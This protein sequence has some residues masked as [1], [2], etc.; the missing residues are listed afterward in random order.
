MSIDLSEFHDVFFEECFDGLDILESGLLTLDQSTD[1]EDINAIFR[2]AHSIKGGSASF[3]FMEISGFTH[4]METL[5]DEMRDGRRQVTRNSIDLLLESVDILRGMVNAARDEEDIDKPLITAVQKKLETML[6]SDET[7]ESVVADN[8]VV[9]NE[10]SDSESAET[11]PSEQ[12]INPHDDLSDDRDQ[13][14]RILYISFYPEQTILQGGNDPERIFRELESLGD[15]VVEIDTSSLPSLGEIKA[16]NCYLGWQLQL[17]GNVTKQD[18]E[19]LFSWVADESKLEISEQT[20]RQEQIDLDAEV[21][22]QTET[23]TQSIP[24]EIAQLDTKADKENSPVDQVVET[25][26]KKPSANTPAKESGSIRVAIDKIDDLINLVGE[27]VITQSMLSQT[28]ADMAVFGSACQEKLCDGLAQLERNTRELQESV[29]QIRML[30]INFTFSRFPRLVRDLSSKMG[31]QIELTM[32]G[33]NTEVDKTVLE[34]IG[35]PLVHLIRNSLDH[36]IE[37][38][39]VRTANGKPAIGN[40]ELSAYHEGGDIIIKV[41][42]DGA[43]LNRDRILA[44]AIDKGLAS[45]NEALTD[46]RIYNLIFA[47][48]F[49]TAEQVSDVSGRGV[50]MDVV[51][52]NVRDLGGNVTIN[53]NEGAGSTV[54]I[55]LPLT[56]AILDGQLARVG[57]ETYIVSLVS[58][59]ESLQIKTEN[60][61]SVTGQSELYQLRDEYIPIIRLNDLLD[62]KTAKTNLE[63]GLLI[64]VDADGQRVGLFVDELMGQQQVVIK[65]IETNFTHIQGISGATILGDGTVALIM[66]VPGLI[67]RH[68]DHCQIFTEVA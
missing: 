13:D 21:E 12:N 68:F 28:G 62:I 26:K 34:K 32:T 43:G 35:D 66:D 48:G 1:V 54:T 30:P 5:L 49:S 7:A 53:S 36:G 16:D 37:M 52:R 15:L 3:G 65:S 25:A 55:R 38:P 6:A 27:L 2:A 39:D 10:A 47:P 42:D 44:K 63:D 64:I 59:I 56:L 29:L 41:I 19:E 23:Q 51:R 4:V 20:T 45:E 58:I 9:E 22:L 33:E 50:G 67:Q 14:T 40:I 24:V 31:K 60:L 18:I 8:T 61:S 46:E 17:T 11:T 57:G